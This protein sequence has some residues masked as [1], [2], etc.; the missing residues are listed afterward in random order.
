MINWCIV[1]SI[2][3]MGREIFVSRANIFARVIKTVGMMKAL[4]GDG[5]LAHFKIK[6][7]VLSRYLL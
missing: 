1:V 6:V 3:Q 7:R 2:A 5:L 4:W